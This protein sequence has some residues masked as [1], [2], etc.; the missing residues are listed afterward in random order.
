MD[1]LS[2]KFLRSSILIDFSCHNLAQLKM[3]YRFKDTKKRYN[4]AGNE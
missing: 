3:R 4:A 1:F 2:L